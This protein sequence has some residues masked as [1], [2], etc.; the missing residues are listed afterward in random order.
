MTSAF[1]DE[2]WWPVHI[3]DVKNSFRIEL[4]RRYNRHMILKQIKGHHHHQQCGTLQQHVGRAYGLGLVSRY[5]T[6]NIE[7]EGRTA[8]STFFR[9]QQI[10][11]SYQPHR[12][13]SSWKSPCLDVLFQARVWTCFFNY[14]RLTSRM[15]VNID[16]KAYDVRLIAKTD[17]YVFSTVSYR[18]PHTDSQLFFN[19]LHITKINLN[20]SC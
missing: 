6:R 2:F 17:N 18:S 3:L 20:K 7:S 16:I 4:H 1:C 14:L 15:L 10:I 5:A 13:V 12:Y 19:R 9:S 11:F 8:L